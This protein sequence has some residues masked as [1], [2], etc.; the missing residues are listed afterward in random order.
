MRAMRSRGACRV[1]C[2]R[3]W[4]SASSSSHI[5][6]GRRV[7]TVI[8]VLSPSN[9]TVGPGRDLYVKKQEELRAGGVSLVEIDLLRAGT[10]VLSDPLDRI[11]EGHRSAYAVC[12]RRGWK[13]FE[14]EYYRLPL[15]DRLPAIP[16]P[17]RR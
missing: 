13:P 1:A 15:R 11:P 2:W 7:V 14:I 3:E 5:K 16:I 12:A 9:K 4:T 17:L 10:R 6:S 8:E